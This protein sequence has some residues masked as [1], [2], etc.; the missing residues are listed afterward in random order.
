MKTEHLNELALGLLNELGDLCGIDTTLDDS[1][2][3]SR[4]ETE[5][6]SFWTIQLP[7]LAKEFISYVDRGYVDPNGF[8]GFHKE[9]L[10][11]ELLGAFFDKVFARYSGWLLDEPCTNAIYSIRQLCCFL[12]KV[13]IECTEERIR[14]AL[15]QYIE[16]D[17]Q[18]GTLADTWDD[19]FLTRFQVMSSR[20]WGR[21]LNTVE[22]RLVDDLVSPRHGPGSTADKLLG[23]QKWRQRTWTDRLEEVFPH[24]AYLAPRWGVF[25]TLDDVEL[26]NPDA[27]LPVKVITVPKTQASP[28]II[29]V[30]PTCMQYMQQALL[31]EF[32][33]CLEN[34]TISRGFVGI[35]DQ[36]PNQDL[37]FEGSL[38][39]TIAT[40]DL[41]EASDRVSYRLVE[42]MLA[43]TPELAQ[44]V[45][46]CRSRTARV[47]IKKGTNEV[48]HLV[49]LNKFASMGS[50][51][52]FP[53]EAMVFTTIVFMGIESALNRR[54][55]NSDIS[56]LVGKVRVYGDD[57]CIPVD[58]MQPVIA[59]LEAHG[60]KVNER[61]SFGTGRFRES[62]G[63]DYYDGVDVTIVRCRRLLP[64]SRR[65][66]EEMV[67]LVS[68]RNQLYKAG[69]WGL[70]KH[71]DTYI[72]GLIPFPVVAET[73]PVLGRHS[74]L[75][76]EGQRLCSRLHIPLVKGCVVKAI[77][78][79]NILDGYDA[80]LKWFLEGGKTDPL[81][82]ADPLDKDHLMRSGRPSAVHIKLRWASV[83]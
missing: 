53:I 11:P 14:L 30:E 80:L 7:Q 9:G 37:A 63:K 46:A 55:H 77:L 49:R 70:T 43:N 64:A 3:R 20:I 58:M 51:L 73:S 33:D 50:A 23:N 31:C 66:A 1:I 5:G 61:K 82:F 60:L 57:I 59:M 13:E 71:L 52:T 6:L 10:L 36:G 17:E 24:G 41:S 12:E 45:D 35:R 76:K 25:D 65:D 22:R 34:V 16:T 38:L 15:E 29:A 62:C 18:V 21:L 32:V 56:L 69:L 26:L 79:V 4:V 2:I 67:S 81:G 8:V 72:E 74:F 78:P 47:L 44:M 27:E 19:E 75:P 28:R 48:E 54:L 68:L 40:L 39:G 83:F 42:T